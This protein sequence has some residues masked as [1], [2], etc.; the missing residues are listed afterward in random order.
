MFAID[1]ASDMALE[2]LF[3]GSMQVSTII[4]KKLSVNGLQIEISLFCGL[5][6]LSDIVATFFMLRV[7]CPSQA[8][9]TYVATLD[10]D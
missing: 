3:V 7:F 6:A 1:C 10:A 9:L 8:V 4:W 2:H 5:A